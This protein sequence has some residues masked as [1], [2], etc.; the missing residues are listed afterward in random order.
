M[1]RN[2][3]LLILLALLMCLMFA[4]C[5]GKGPAEVKVLWCAPAA[6]MRFSD[7]AGDNAI[8]PAVTVNGTDCEVRQINITD[9]DGGG[10]L[11]LDDEFEIVRFKAHGEYT[12][13]MEFELPEGVVTDEAH[14][15]C[16][17]PCDQIE[18][19]GSTL[20]LSWEWDLDKL[21]EEDY[22][23]M[24]ANLYSPDL[25]AGQ[26]PAELTEEISVT[27][28]SDKVGKQTDTTVYREVQWYKSIY[29]GS[30]H[31]PFTEMGMDEPFEDGNFYRVEFTAS[32]KKLLEMPPHT[33]YLA[34]YGE[35]GVWGGEVYF[36]GDKS[37]FVR[38]YY[39][40]LGTA[41]KEYKI[42]AEVYA[43]RIGMNTAE[44]TDNI[45][46]LQS[47]NH[48]QVTYLWATSV[49][50]GIWETMGESELFDSRPEE[51]RY[52][53]VT[54][55]IPV[56]DDYDEE[57]SPVFITCDK[58]RSIAAPL[59]QYPGN[60]KHVVLNIVFRASDL[61][62]APNSTDVVVSL[63][64]VSLGDSIREVTDRVTVTAKG[65]PVEIL[66]TSWT[67]SL[68][69]G[70]KLLEYT[71][72]ETFEPALATGYG[73]E[74]ITGYR[75]RIEV[76]YS[77]L[78]NEKAFS[79]FAVDGSPVVGRDR[80]RGASSAMDGTQSVYLFIDLDT[81]C[82]QKEFVF[83]GV[84]DLYINSMT[85]DYG[86]TISEAS[87]D[88]FIT[89]YTA[90][91]A[92]LTGKNKT[93][94]WTAVNV[95]GKE[96]TLE[97]SDVFACD[98]NVVMYVMSLTLENTGMTPGTEIRS[99]VA[100]PVTSSFCSN[101]DDNGAVSL[102]LIYS[103]DAL[104]CGVIRYNMTYIGAGDTAEEA[105]V[106][107]PDAGCYVGGGRQWTLEVES[108]SFREA[109]SIIPATAMGIHERTMES[110]D[111]FSADKQYCMDV[112]LKLPQNR[113]AGLAVA[114]VTDMLYGF[115]FGPV[116]LKGSTAVIHL[117]FTPVTD[118]SCSHN[119]SCTVEPGK[120]AT[121]TEA[122]EGKYTCAY[123]GDSYTAVIPALGHDMKATASK[124]VTC[125]E[126]GYTIYTCSRCTA[127]SELTL[128]AT[129]HNNVWAW[130]T[131]NHWTACGTCGK[132]AN[133]DNRGRHD[134]TWLYEHRI[135]GVLYDRYSCSI[136]GGEYDVPVIN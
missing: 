83:T 68:S 129:G 19:L 51:D 69:S 50:D 84:V 97:S 58:C 86:M 88:S 48:S 47:P 1:K 110:A 52:Y 114:E 74:T 95:A 106:K 38:I 82:M 16:D 45:A 109:D 119:Y 135:D 24:T 55:D 125:T 112:V 87:T 107:A 130:D 102:R 121:C 36:V 37:A 46:L 99:H 76:P 72:L 91:N 61:G 39:E 40:N 42:E 132:V 8:Y 89:A 54:I 35:G 20:N 18:I 32:S 79:T 98:A 67:A 80:N 85:P 7:Y 22:A 78:L 41:P 64:D 2:S 116:E 62:V 12:A 128:P 34:A 60:R 100:G 13:I 53:R 118:G 27:F 126:S 108:I 113:S 28:S 33:A 123:C 77:E 9:P 26:T 136:C 127:T 17:P 5:G 124:A 104:D 73:M 70:S 117:I 10:F 29:M 103:A 3:M 23:F 44:A 57:N 63:G 31:A 49:N 11:S 6:G 120:E 115:V 59:I 14:I 101:V 56:P 21:T 134:G 25:K 96:V 131:N 15:T 66:S 71:G 111:R 81:A 65:Q 75:L 122:G 90:N 30:G 94:S 4:G 43:P 105:T 93:V 92:F 133:P